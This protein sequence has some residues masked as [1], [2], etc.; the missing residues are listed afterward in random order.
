MKFANLQMSVSCLATLALGNINPRFTTCRSGLRASS[1]QYLSLKDATI[2]ELGA[3]LDSGQFTSVDLVKAYLDRIGEV[4]DV[5]HAVTETNPDALAL[6]T[7]LDAERSAGFT[8]GPLHGI[9]ILIKNNIATDDKLNTT[10][11]SYSLLG[12]RVPRDSAIANKLRSAGAI[13]LGKANL[14]QWANFRSNNSTNGWSALGGQVYGPYYP[15]QDPSGS[16]SG[17]AVSSTLGL[18]SGTLGSE[19]DGS[20]ISPSSKNNNVGI[21]PTV[22]LTSR[23][24]VIPISEHQDTVGPIARTVKDAA[25][26]L[27]A[28]A[29]VDPY[30]NY[31][32]AIPDNG[33]I[34]DYV[35]ACQLSALSGARIGV[36]R[37]AI[38][39]LS[40]SISSAQVTAFEEAISVLEAAGATIVDNTNFTA[41]AEFLNSTVEMQVLQAD[42]LVNLASYLELLTE[43]P[44]N[45]TSLA[46]VRDF[47]QSFP[48]EEY[49]ARDT[50]VWDDTIFKQGWNNTD[51]RFW[52]AYQQNLY[53]G[54]EG[55]LLGAI[56]R[57]NL[58]AVILPSDQ[59]PTFAAG[60]GA[61]IVTVPL[62]FSPANMTVVKNSWGLV[63]DGPNIPF[64]LSFMGAK[65]TEAKLIGFAYAF[66]QRT[67]IRDQQQPYIVPSTELI[68]VVG[69]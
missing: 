57:N 16:S 49:P 18:A 37:N 22:G 14:S 69:Q 48:A 61:P 45:V 46:G 51:P 56:E 47:T 66:E 1:Q 60:V 20:I 58:D 24:L 10:A 68:D 62:G 11:G 59:S 53:Y 39:L 65:F 2:D 19:T 27:Q 36:A 44:N 50:A 3:G 7:E 38:E 5:L 8:R 33:T 23:N 52:P 43:N 63:T 25:I 41:A 15:N 54:G 26:I 4:N 17:S 64:G 13:I 31:T 28:I 67:N 6:A 29:G 12:A 9:P 35:A 30:D 32:S 42:F 34:P 55:G 21:K 40:S